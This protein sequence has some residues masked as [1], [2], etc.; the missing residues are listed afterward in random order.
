MYVEVDFNLDE[1]ELAIAT[2][3]DQYENQR[4]RF[5]GISW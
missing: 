4:L 5:K 1:H 3:K 2:L